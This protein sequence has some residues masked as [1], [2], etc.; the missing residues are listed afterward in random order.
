[1]SVLIV[2][3]G[4]GRGRGDS[5]G[6][7]F[8][9]YLRAERPRLAQSLRFWT[10]GSAPPA[11]DGVDV[12]VFWLAD[13]LRELYPE[14][15]Q[16]AQSIADE[17]S[18]RRLRLINA[19]EALS[20]TTKSVQSKRWLSAGIPAATCVP[21]LDRAEF[22]IRVRELDFPA[23]VRPDRLHSQ[24]ATYFCR[25][26]GEAARLNDEQLV[27]PGVIVAF[28]DTREGYRTSLP[29]SIWARFFHKKRAFVFGDRVVPNHIFFSKSPIVGLTS[30]T[31][32]RYRGKR[33]HLTPVLR[34]RKWERDAVR[35]DNAFWQRA[36]EAPEA[37]LRAARALD[38]EVVALD[39]STHFDGSVML[40]E[41]NPHFALPRWQDGVL[42]RLRRL[43]ERIRGFAVAHGDFL[44]DLVGHSAASRSA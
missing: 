43:E 2:R 21:F 23:I 24:A 27:Y 28:V 6:T 44:E 30:S 1:M 20:H 22:E 26:A 12:V 36:P 25:T 32:A 29:G 3:H 31:F 4:P 35:V 14:C 8:L 16:E 10:T 41:A 11:L 5:F 17:A 38:L 39:Y 9:D 37:M 18:R 19:P 34:F 40:W 15:Y 13:P 33:R 7:P 42:P